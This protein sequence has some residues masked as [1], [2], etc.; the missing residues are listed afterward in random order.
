MADIITRD[1]A[2][3]SWTLY[4]VKSTNSIKKDH[5]LDLS[6][7]RVAFE[8][9]GYTIGKVKVI[10]LNKDYRRRPQVV[11]KDLLM[12]SDVTSEVAELVETLRAQPRMH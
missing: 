12:E 6:F 5:I 4:E 9:A 8:D 3:E 7:Q 10:Y 1:D 11:P 2:S